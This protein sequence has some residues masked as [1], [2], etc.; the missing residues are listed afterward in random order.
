MNQRTHKIEQLLQNDLKIINLGIQT[1]YHS[2]KNQGAEVVQIEWR[3]PAGGK[4]KLIEILDRL[5]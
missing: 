2:L 5:K 3:P 4:R 1:F